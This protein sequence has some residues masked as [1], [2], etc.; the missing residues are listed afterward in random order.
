MPPPAE[1]IARAILCFFFE[2]ERDP[3][4]LPLFP[5]IAEVNPFGLKIGFIFNPFPFPPINT[6]RDLL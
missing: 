5:E 1:G 2:W 3:E 6:R 4:F